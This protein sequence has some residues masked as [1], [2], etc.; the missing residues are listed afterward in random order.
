[1]SNHLARRYPV[2]AANVPALPLATLPTPVTQHRIADAHRPLSITVKCDDQSGLPYGGNKVRKLEYLLQHALQRSAGRI[3]TYGAAGSNHALATAIYS[4]QL[5]VPCTCL[6][7]QQPV[8]PGISRT[9]LLHQQLGTE[10]VRFGGTYSA[11]LEIQRDHLQGRNLWLLPMGGSAW[12]GCL[13]FVNAALELAAQ[14]DNGELVVPDTVYVAMG[15]MGTVAGLALGFALADLPIE[16]QAVRVTD[17][18]VAN[19]AALARLLQKTASLMRRCDPA[20]PDDLATKARI[21]FRDDFF[22]DGYGRSTPAADAAI[23]FAR[24]KLGIELESTYSGKA[25]AALLADSKR[26]DAGELLF[27]NTYNSLEVPLE[28]NLQP[29]FNVIPPEFARYFEAT[30]N[31]EGAS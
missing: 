24:S 13:G 12:R 17:A 18:R 26:N 22:G 5:G 27:W 16:I 20:I 21:V 31:S 19:P 10:I 23:D 15:T 30:T 3:A 28:P 8:K 2:L 25:M 11:R 4:R 7:S 14:I 6:L 1:M 29:D 9:L